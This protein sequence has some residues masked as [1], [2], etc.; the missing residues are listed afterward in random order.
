[1]LGFRISRKQNDPNHEEIFVNYKHKRGMTITSKTEACKQIM[2]PS[3]SNIKIKCTFTNLDIKDLQQLQEV[4]LTALSFR[5][6][7]LI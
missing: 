6:V 1:M 7:I 4:I 3:A 2:N 5:V